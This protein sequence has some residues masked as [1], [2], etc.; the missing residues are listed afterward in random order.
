MNP[1]QRRGLIL[2]VM[3]TLLAIAV[4]VGVVMYVQDVSSKTG[5]TTEV[6]VAKTDINVF[7]PIS[8]DQLT[9]QTVPNR[10]ITP[11]MITSKDQFS[12]QKASTRI[13]QGSYLQTDM[14]E[15]ASSLEDG[16]R[17][18]TISF[19]AAAGVS[20][21]VAPDDNVDVIASFARA[22]EN[23]QGEQAYK[24]ADIPYNV[25][26]VI[27]SNAKVV[28]VGQPVDPNAVVGAADQTG[29]QVGSV[30]VT[31]AVSV[32]EAGRL[33]YAEAFAISMRIMRLSNNETGTQV[34]ENDKSFDDRDLQDT[35]KLEGGGE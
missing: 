5:P 4:F 6:Y 30:P 19:D 26:G 18:I 32:E 11:Q 29:A 12:G 3:A 23:D 35:L 24:R 31:F 34:D 8:E 14:I 7:Q 15:P 33:S 28:S 2:M 22:R 27:V 10:Y 25:S 16:Q 21:R 17:E 9:T 13:A 1:K 20:G